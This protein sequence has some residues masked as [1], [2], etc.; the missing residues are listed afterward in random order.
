MGW[1]EN[2]KFKKNYCFNFQGLQNEWTSNILL[3]AKVHHV[4][5][6]DPNY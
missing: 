5:F 2:L 6:N 1:D 4:D 3:F